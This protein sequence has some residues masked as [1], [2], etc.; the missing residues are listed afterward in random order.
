MHAYDK[1]VLV[2]RSIENRHLTKSGGMRVHPPQKIVVA[3]FRRRLFEPR[4]TY[5]LRVHCTHD[6]PASP[7]LAG[8]ID[9][10]KDDQQTVT[11]IGVQLTLQFR[12]AIQIVLQLGLGLIFRFMRPV[13]IGIDIG[14]LDLAAGFDL[15]PLGK[16]HGN[17]LSLGDQ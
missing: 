15:Q 8:S 16:I 12:D 17:T 11:A 5:A 10:L 4:D 6:M 2:V 14:E 9:S 1:N 13:K 3:L 7:V